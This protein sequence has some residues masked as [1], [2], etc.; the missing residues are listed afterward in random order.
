MKQLILVR[1]GKA[2]QQNY[3]RDYNRNLTT[4]GIN[5]AHLIGQKVK[6]EISGKTAFISSPANRAIQTARIFAGE[7]SFPEGQIKEFV[8]L[9]DWVTTTDFLDIIGEIHDDVDTILAFGHNPTKLVLAERFA[10]QFNGHMPTSCAVGILFD[11]EKWS[12]LEANAGKLYF[13][14]YPK[15]L[16][17]E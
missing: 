2:E 5:D 13:H 16:K 14:Y 9:Y 17:I 8:K 6:S 7:L 1:H 3:S 11:V 15:K 10:P 4:R 12:Q